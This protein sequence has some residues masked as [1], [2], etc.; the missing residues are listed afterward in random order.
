[1]QQVAALTEQTSVGCPF[2]EIIIIIHWEPVGARTP[3]TEAAGS[4]SFAEDYEHFS[5]R[6]SSGFA[7]S[8]RLVRDQWVICHDPS[9]ITSLK[10]HV[11]WRNGDASSIGERQLSVRR[12]RKKTRMMAMISQGCSSYQVENRLFILVFCEWRLSRF[13]FHDFRGRSCF[14]KCQRYIGENMNV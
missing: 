10:L 8:R 4:T 9:T 3:K 1:M 2:F 12:E 14:L 13:G 6:S 7:S 11:T 5:R